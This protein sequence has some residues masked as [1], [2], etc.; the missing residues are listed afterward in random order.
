MRIFISIF[1]LILASLPASANDSEAEIALGGLRLKPS[2][3]ISLDREDLFI[4]PTEVRVDYLFTNHGKADVDALV[5][6]PL[7]DIVFNED[8]PRGELNYKRDVGFST[9]VNGKPVDYEWVEQAI[10]NDTDVTGRVKAAGLPLH[11]DEQG[12]RD[13]ASKAPANL[14]D[15][16]VADGL[17]D[18]YGDATTTVYDAKWKLRTT[19]TRHQ[20]FPAGKTIEVH[21]RYKPIAGGSVAGALEKTART[22]DWALEHQKAYCIEKG[23]FAAFDKANASHQGPDGFAPYSEIWLGY[24]LKSGANWE[25]PIKDFRLVIDKGKPDNLL[26]LCAEGVKKISPTQFEIR[27]TNFEPKDDLAILIV[28]WAD[29]E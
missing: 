13:A 22:E 28:N 4:S 21:H 27:K 15:A 3:T 7:P 19:V 20:V 14:R 10:F 24:V 2:D 16:L 29:Q 5:A 9:I 12:F 26:S 23:W 1:L 8:S 25:G 11:G 17:L 6:F 18:K